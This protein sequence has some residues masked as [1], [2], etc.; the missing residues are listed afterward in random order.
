MNATVE[1]ALN[2][3][4]MGNAEWRLI[5]AR[6]NQVFRVDQA[7]NSFALR[8]HRKG[9]RSD[10][11]LWSE[12][13][14]L[15]AVADGGLHVPA[16]IRS[17]SGE[18]LHIVDGF[19]VDVLTWLS[20]KPVGA[21]GEDLALSDRTGFFR[22]LGRE[23][24]RLHNICDAWTLPDGFTIICRFCWRC[25][26]CLSDGANDFRKWA[27]IFGTGEMYPFIIHFYNPYYSE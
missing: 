22:D 19:Q 25:F 5:A 7:G 27:V 9:L 3:W 13:A 21:T 2:L 23:M 12:L 18:F 20:G 10:P 16:P 17:K 8:L 11:Q 24:A 4:G 14:W 6:E 15:S 26:C 1:K